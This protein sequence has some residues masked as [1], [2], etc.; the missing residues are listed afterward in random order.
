MDGI[1]LDRWVKQACPA[2]RVVIFSIRSDEFHVLAALRAGARDYILKTAI[3]EQL[4]S[5]LDKVY[6]GSYYLSGEL[7]ERVIEYYYR[8]DHK[9][10]PFETL[11][12]KEK[13]VMLLAR[14]GLTSHEIAEQL[15]IKPCTVE[16]HCFNAMK[17][18]HLRNQT[19]LVRYFMEEPGVEH[20]RAK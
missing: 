17:K 7:S 3:F 12:R 11:P 1:E 4:V 15:Y 5:A 18:L 9:G 8:S 14:E 6:S 19:E 16:T 10:T 13:E 20:V 2:T